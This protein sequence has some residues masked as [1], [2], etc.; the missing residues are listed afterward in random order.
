MT[1][2]DDIEALPLFIMEEQLED[3][4]WK[5]IHFWLLKFRDIVDRFA[6]DE[7]CQPQFRVRRVKTW[8]EAQTLED[9]GNTR[10]QLPLNMMHIKWVTA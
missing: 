1:E 6:N 10:L 9:T 7:L 3:G 5:P 4:Q 2:N 8:A